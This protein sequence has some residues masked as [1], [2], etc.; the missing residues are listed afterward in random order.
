MPS[1]GWYGLK[2][3]INKVKNMMKIIDAKYK[4]LAALS[5][6][7]PLRLACSDM[8]GKMTLGVRAVLMKWRL[9]RR[10][11]P[12]NDGGGRR[13]SS[14]IPPPTPLNSRD[15]L[16]KEPAPMHR[17][18][19]G[20]C[21]KAIPLLRTTD[22]L[23]KPTLRKLFATALKIKSCLSIASSFYLAVEGNF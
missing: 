18:G 4:D 1:W 20:Q 2:I 9:P 12:R 15:K 23:S 17:R 5:F 7:C 3:F 13:G 22:G 8:I 11:T 19:H 16:S 10:Y 14:G 6:S 21:N